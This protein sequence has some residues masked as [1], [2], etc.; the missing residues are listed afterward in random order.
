LIL[1]ETSLRMY[2]RN[3]FLFCVVA[4]ASFV[5]MLALFI[6]ASASFVRMLG[7]L[8][9]FI[10]AVVCALLFDAGCS[11]RRACIAAALSC[12]GVGVA[13]A[14]NTLTAGQAFFEQR[15]RAVVFALGAE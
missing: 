4:S 3:K 15:Q 2:V 1:I 7:D 11:V 8:A 6:V 10:R 14:K 9:L 5:R 12:S 13:V